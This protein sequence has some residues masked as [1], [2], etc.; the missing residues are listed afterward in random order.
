MLLDQACASLIQDIS[1]KDRSFILTGNT[2]LPLVVMHDR[3]KSF[4]IYPMHISEG[5][6]YSIEASNDTRNKRFDEVR[7]A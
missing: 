6:L 1:S 4:S 3:T 5:V 2:L 7:T